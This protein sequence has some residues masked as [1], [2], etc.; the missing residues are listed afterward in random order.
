MQ[1]AVERREEEGEGG[2][3][4]EARETSDYGRRLGR[5]K[6]NT[7]GYVLFPI[8][9]SSLQDNFTSQNDW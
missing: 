9:L 3:R 4:R 1:T 2:E 5:S 8:M 6:A 7:N